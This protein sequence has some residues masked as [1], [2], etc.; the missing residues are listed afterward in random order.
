LPAE[1][2]AHI[3]AWDLLAQFLLQSKAHHP[4]QYKLSVFDEIAQIGLIKADV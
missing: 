1:R 4:P 3:V 2:Q